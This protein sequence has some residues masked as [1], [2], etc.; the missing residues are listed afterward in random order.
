MKLAIIGGGGKIS[1][2][3]I[4]QL[5]N[6]IHD[7]PLTFALYG[8]NEEKIND[9]L[10]LSKRFNA[11]NGELLVCKSIEEALEGAE[12]VFYCATNGTDDFAGLRSMGITNGAHILHIGQKVSEICP[13]AWFMVATNP[14][15]VPLMAVR[16][17]YG[18]K[19]SIA[20]CNAAMFGKKLLSSFYGVAENRLTM[21][22]FGV[23]HEF[24]YYDLRL[25]GKNIYDDLRKRLP[26]EYNRDSIMA[27]QFHKEFPEWSY[28]FANTIEIMR[29]TGFLSAPIGGSKRYKNLPITDMWSI[30]SRPTAADFKKMM[31]PDQTDEQILKV[32]L[33]CGGGIPIYSAEL[34]K[35][36]IRSDGGEHS[37]ITF[38]DG[39]APMYPA[40]SMLQMSC[41]V[42][43]DKLTQPDLS[44]VDPYIHA[45]LASRIFQNHLMAQALAYQDD[46]KLRQALSI[47]PE[48]I[49]ITETDNF[50]ETHKSV[51][52]FIQ[53]N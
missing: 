37:V 18:F 14:P 34:L 43:L 26:T 31:E 6:D 15:C 35:S 4:F 16:M 8:R 21:H 1:S 46:L 42:T 38:N 28:G 51:E 39:A 3:V 45:V 24:W 40:E 50:L 52:P 7:V 20:L 47:Y 49:D 17:R 23:N 19:K 27:D 5:L 53:L 25:D 10:T 2:A 32:A 29:L 33:R 12:I 22:E 48:R 11:G 9:T 13:N 41:G 30:A 44:G 36:M